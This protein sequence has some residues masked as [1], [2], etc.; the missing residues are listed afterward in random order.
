[1][2]CLSRFGC[3]VVLTSTLMDVIEQTSR[4]DFI[5]KPAAGIALIYSGIP[6][7]HRQCLAW[8]ITSRCTEHIIYEQLTL[9]PK[10]VAS[11]SVFQ[12][13]PECTSKQESRVCEY[14]LLMIENMQIFDLGRFMRFVTGSSVCNAGQITVTFNGLSGLRR[15]PIAHTC[16]CSLELPSSYIKELMTIL[17]KPSDE[18]S[19]RMG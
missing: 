19:W 7:R 3:R 4:C 9:T 13:E 10:K 2:T 14:V 12:I 18:Y 6:D 1:M 16:D 17:S 15:R 8:K 11:C 5:S